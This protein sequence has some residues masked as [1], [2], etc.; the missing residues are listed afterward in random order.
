VTFQVESL[1]AR[2]LLEGL[3]A[4]QHVSSLFCHG[5]GSL[6][7]IHQNGILM[8]P[9][10]PH[11]GVALRPDGGSKRELSRISDRKSTLTWQ[12]GRR[13]I[14]RN[15]K[16]EIGNSGWSPSAGGNYAQYRFSAVLFPLLVLEYSQ[17]SME[18]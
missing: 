15:S 8:L 14:R 2:E 5:V 11:V 1:I 13:I 3:L 12:G 9:V 6:G 18:F 7:L 16:V 10:S 17:R 4:G